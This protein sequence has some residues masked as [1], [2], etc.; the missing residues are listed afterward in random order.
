[1][2]QAVTKRTKECLIEQK[3]KFVFDVQIKHLDNSVRIISCLQRKS[4]K[5]LLGTSSNCLFKAE[6]A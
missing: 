1:M 2:P 4:N 6:I 3:A 5:L